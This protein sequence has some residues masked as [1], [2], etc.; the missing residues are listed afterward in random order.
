ML[1]I[2]FAAR[3]DIRLISAQQGDRKGRPYWPIIFIPGDQQKYIH[4]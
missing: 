3:T 1:R 4:K 2:A